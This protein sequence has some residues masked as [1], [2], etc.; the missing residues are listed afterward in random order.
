MKE[1]ITTSPE[2]ANTVEIPRPGGD[3]VRIV[4]TSPVVIEAPG[5][6]TYPR[7]T[8][9]YVEDSEPS[10]GHG[11]ASAA[12][13][14]NYAASIL[15]DSHLEVLSSVGSSAVVLH[16]GQWAF[17]VMR[18]PSYY[19]YYED[20]A[21]AMGLMY[22]LGLAPA[23]YILM[24]AAREFRTE[25]KSGTPKRYF[26]DEPIPRVE[27]PGPLPIIA[28]EK[29]SIAPL[30][31]LPVKKA[32][33][34]FDRILDLTLPHGIIFGGVKPFVDQKTGT[35]KFIDLGGLS[36]YNPSMRYSTRGTQARDRY[37]GISD[38][39]VQVTQCVDSL[40]SRF[41]GGYQQPRVS[42][43]AILE[44]LQSK[45]RRGITELMAYQLELNNY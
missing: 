12:R 36:Q 16:D 44:T 11:P 37:P 14:L 22:K 17:K 3:S 33:R 45:G 5:E 1:Y 24:D 27:T 38:D 15:P 23:P 28:M 30:H 32:V 35:V 10:L 25:T 34:E 7:S 19:S 2:Y 8:K 40:F 39:D 18:K 13:A 43:E 41:T 9:E 4:A 26:S 21:A 31:S 42:E 20:E 6:E 29:L